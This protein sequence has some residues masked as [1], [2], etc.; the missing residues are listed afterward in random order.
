M[1]TADV[2]TRHTADELLEMPDSKSFELVDGLLVER[3]M[4]LESSWINAQMLI[5]LGVYLQ[6]KDLGRVFDSE[7]SYQCFGDDRET[8]RKPDVSFI[9]KGRLPNETLTRGHSQIPPDFAIEVVSPNDRV[10]ELQSKVADYLAA[11]V[12]LVWVV[13]PADRSVTVYS[14][15]SDQPVVVREGSELTG[16]DVLPE[17]RCS[18]SSLFPPGKK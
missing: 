1:S 6:G 11:G 10:Y 2:G 15:E 16:G 5:L 13:N 18:V 14:Q 3:N 17:F 9:R 7:A 4:G 8:V 12:S